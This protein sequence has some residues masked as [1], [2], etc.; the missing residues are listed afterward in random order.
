MKTPIEGCSRY[1]LSF[2]S[3]IAELP[4]SILTRFNNLLKNLSSASGVWVGIHVSTHLSVFIFTVCYRWGGNLE[5]IPNSSVLM[6][7]LVV[8]GIT[9]VNTLNLLRVQKRGCCSAVCVFLVGR[10]SQQITANTLILQPD[11]VPLIPG[12]SDTGSRSVKILK[13]LCRFSRTRSSVLS[14]AGTAQGP[15]SCL[16]PGILHRR[17]N[18][19]HFSPPHLGTHTRLLLILS[20]VPWFNECLLS[21]YLLTEKKKY[22]AW[23]LSIMSYLA[24]I[25]KTSSLGHSVSEN[26]DK[27]L[28]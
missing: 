13:H 21:I 25:L 28:R 9:G 11:L 2:S 4:E 20:F 8:W 6:M 7:T 24:D 17:A 15:L 3:E 18:A 1:F 26:T 5:G 12:I 14:G 10:S 19:F 23:K 22:T 16:Q 27:F